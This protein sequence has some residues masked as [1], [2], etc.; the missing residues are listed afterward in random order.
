LELIKAFHILLKT[1][2]LITVN[3]S[4]FNKNK[5]TESPAL[6]DIRHKI[7]HGEISNINES[8]LLLVDHHVLKIEKLALRYIWRIM[9]NCLDI[10]NRRSKMTVS[11]NMDLNNG[12][13][14]NRDMYKGPVEM[15]IL[16]YNRL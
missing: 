3:E 12:I 13:L 2:G 7:A 9:N 11:M 15:S 16:Y 5:E 10:Y 14:S 4:F 8:D 6:Y 1:N